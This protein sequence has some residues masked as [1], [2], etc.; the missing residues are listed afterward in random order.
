MQLLLYN[1]EMPR[2]A[3]IIATGYP[4]HITQRGNNRAMVFFDDDD[5]HAYLKF[6]SVYSQRHHLQIWAYCLMGKRKRVEEK[7]GT[8]LFI[9]WQIGIKDVMGQD[10][11][12][13]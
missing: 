8:D 6:L 13:P 12:N 7:K 2:I 10:L 9:C 11:D 5:R 3:R 1:S 4:H